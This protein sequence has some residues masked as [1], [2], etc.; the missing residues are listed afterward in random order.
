MPPVP[1]SRFAVTE[2]C[3]NL[4]HLTHWSGKNVANVTAREAG[5]RRGRPFRRRRGANSGAESASRRN[6]APA[7]RD[8]VTPGATVAKAPPPLDL[9]SLET[10]LKATEKIGVFTKLALKNQVDDLLDQFRAYYGGKLKVTLADL[11]RRYDLLVLKV[12]ALLQDA[13]PPLAHAIA[14]SREAIWGILADPAKFA[15]V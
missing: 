6:R 4:T 14:A 8:A 5:L 7:P 12:L 3:Y 2:A 10:R 11:R 13:D 15:S 1:V 9:K